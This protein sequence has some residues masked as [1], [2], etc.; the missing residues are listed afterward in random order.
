[1]C[2]TIINES[3]IR[4]K[5]ISKRNFLMRNQHLHKVQPIMR[6]PVFALLHQEISETGTDG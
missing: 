5:R 3:K 1:M 6:K 2:E 4:L